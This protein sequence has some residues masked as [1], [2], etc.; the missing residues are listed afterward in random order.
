MDERSKSLLKTLIEHYIADGQPVGSRALS[1][2]SGLD[3]RNDCNSVMCSWDWRI[4]LSF[5]HILPWISLNSST[6]TS[7]HLIWILQDDDSVPCSLPANPQIQ[8][9]RRNLP[10]FLKSYERNHF[11]DFWF[12]CVLSQLWSSGYPGSLNLFVRFC[13]WTN[14]FSSMIVFRGNFRI[15]V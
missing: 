5:R 14:F 13:S 11:S 8:Y 10:G 9:G 15:L 6:D 4:P 12:F 3:F 2:F 7:L 1:K